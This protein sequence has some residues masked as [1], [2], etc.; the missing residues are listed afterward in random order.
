M[1]EDCKSGVK[2]CNLFEVIGKESCKVVTG[3]K[4]PKTPKMRIQMLEAA[5]VAIKYLEMKEIKLVNVGANDIVDGNLKIL[6]GMIWTVIL[7]YVGGRGG[8][9]AG[10]SM[11]DARNC[12]L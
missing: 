7:R 2:L 10:C 11:R 3:T 8:Q 4:M 12:I 9:R 1:A 5:N 6:L